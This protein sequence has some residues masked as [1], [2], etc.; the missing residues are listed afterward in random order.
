M[1]PKITLRPD[2]LTQDTEVLLHFGNGDR[3]S[4]QKVSKEVVDRHDYWVGVI[5]RCG[6]F[7][8][9]VYALVGIDEEVIAREM[10]HRVYGR[11]TVG[12][13]RNAGFELDVYGA[14]QED[15]SAVKV[16]SDYNGANQAWQFD[17][18]GGDLYVITATHS[19]QTLG[20]KGQ[21]QWSELVQ[22][23]GRPMVWKVID[24]GSTIELRAAQN[25][26]LAADL[27]YSTLTNGTTFQMYPANGTCAQRFIPIEK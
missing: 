19:R 27:Y 22:R 17:S 7:A 8:V 9:S 15:G 16:W 21:W 14:S 25:D 13:I 2:E 18:V 3:R 24:N 5:D 20:A 4:I 6:R 12:E 23:K 1:A 11:S 10:P 26:H